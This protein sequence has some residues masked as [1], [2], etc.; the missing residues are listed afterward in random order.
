MFLGFTGKTTIGFHHL[1]NGVATQPTG[2]LCLILL[3]TNKVGCHTVTTM[4]DRLVNKTSKDRNGCWNWTGATKRFGYGYTTIGSRTNGTRKT[5]TT[6]RAMWIAENGAIPDGLWVLHHCDNSKCINP[7]HL[8]LGNREDNVRDRESRGRNIVPNLKHEE[9]PMAKLNWEGVG[10]I[11]SR[12]NSTQQELAD[13]FGV[14]R[15]TIKDV[16]G[17]KTWIPEPPE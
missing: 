3:L 12:R 6:H 7:K 4:R 1:C 5:I 13:E 16:L 17:M 14:S 10:M 15:E 2:C 8:Y 11:R 9:H